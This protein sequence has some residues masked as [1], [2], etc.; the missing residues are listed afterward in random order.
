MYTKSNGTVLDTYKN[1]YTHTLTE[2]SMAYYK[3]SP[4]MNPTKERLWRY[5]ESIYKSETVMLEK[6]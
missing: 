6:V 4:T 5:S 1:N 3:A 2:V